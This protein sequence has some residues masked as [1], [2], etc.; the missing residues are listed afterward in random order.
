MNSGGAIQNFVQAISAHAALPQGGHTM[1]KPD[2]QDFTSCQSGNQS[3]I[4]ETAIDSGTT[5]NANKGV[6]NSVNIGGR[7]G[8]EG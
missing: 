1:P 5:T 2:H 6:D 7:R 3:Q 4:T 8:M